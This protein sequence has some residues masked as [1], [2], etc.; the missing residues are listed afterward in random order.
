MRILHLIHNL[1]GGGAERQLSYLAP[2]LARMG[3]DIHIAYCNEGPDKPELSGVILHWLKSSS[4]YDPYLLWQVF[5]LVRHV[6]PDLLQ[7]WILSMDILGGIAARFSKVPWILREPSSSLAYSGSWKQRLR[8]RVS[9]GVEAIVSNSRGGEDFWRARLP[10]SRRYVIRNG[11][12]IENIDKIPPVLPPAFVNSALEE[13]IA[14]YVGRLTQAESASK[15]IEI[16]LEALAQV[17]RQKRVKAVLCGDGQQKTRLRS[18][19]DRIGL[20]DEVHFTGYLP[21]TSVWALM[22]MASVFV[23][24]SAYEGCPNAV[25]EAMSCGCPLVV[26]DIP[27]HRELLDEE[28]AK[29]VS[30]DHPQE[31]AAAICQ[32][33]S[34][35]QEAQR[36]ARLAK[37]KVAI[38]SVASMA[39]QYEKLYREVL[40]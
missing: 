16:F 5:R 38:Y 3:H 12:P 17:R 23:T 36:R 19:T 39:V 1:S 14:L 34:A 4:N 35:P 29:L 27:A 8:I 33:V 18:F 20:G 28:T 13:P 9:C 11:L 24:L 37:E 40:G 25:M 22:K 7:T 26:S 6:K 30:H 21:T 31:V 2:E 10:T 32:T 15:N